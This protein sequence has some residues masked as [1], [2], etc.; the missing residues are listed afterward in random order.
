MKKTFPANIHGTIF[1]IDEDAYVR[2]NNYLDQLHKAFPGTEGEE[3][4]GDIEAR[5]NEILSIRHEGRSGVVSIL[6]VDEIIEQMGTPQDMGAPETKNDSSEEPADG[7]EGATAPPPFNAEEQKRPAKRL[8]RNERDKMLGGVLSGIACYLGW[9]KFILR[10]LYLL[11]TLFT[12]FW[13]GTF[14]YLIAWMIIPP[15]R[16]R[17]DYLEMQGEPVTISNIGRTFLDERLASDGNDIGARTISLVIKVILA[18]LGIFGLCCVIGLTIYLGIRIWGI[19]SYITTNNIYLIENASFPV[20][21]S[22]VPVLEPLGAVFGSI[23]LILAAICVVWGSA[24][25]VF[26]T[27]R[28]AA[29][30]VFTL[31]VIICALLALAGTLMM[32]S[33]YMPHHLYY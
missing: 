1:Y 25:V 11:L 9:N 32:V 19:I 27:R 33:H 20:F 15:A 8:F 6:E 18:V 4:T 24:S 10:L 17:R 31:V 13:P 23:A 3:I 14:I 16:T 30:T 2:L 7:V 5:I 29:S 22:T 12:Y 28:P 21:N 26:K